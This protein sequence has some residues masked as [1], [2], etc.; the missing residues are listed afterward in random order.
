MKNNDRQE[1][2]T[3]KVHACGFEL[4]LTVNFRPDGQPGEVFI[5]VAKEGSTVSGFLNA[6]CATL[7]AALTSNTPWPKMRDQLLGTRFEPRDDD[8]PSLV[9]AVAQTIEDLTTHKGAPS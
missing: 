3:K 4:Y 7:T 5:R 8:N 1:G 9:H 6:L 2:L